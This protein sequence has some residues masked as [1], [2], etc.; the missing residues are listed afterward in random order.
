M[1]KCKKFATALSM[2]ALILP[3]GAGYAAAEE[4]PLDCTDGTM[5]PGLGIFNIQAGYSSSQPAPTG[6]VWGKVTAETVGENTKTVEA[7]T[8]ETEFTYR[9]R[10][11]AQKTAPTHFSISLTTTG[12][13]E[14]GYRIYLTDE[15]K[16]KIKD[17]DCTLNPK[18]IPAQG[19]ATATCPLLKNAKYFEIWHEDPGML[20]MMGR[21]VINTDNIPKAGAG[22]A[23]D[24]DLKIKYSGSSDAPAS[25]LLSATVNAGT[26][27]GTFTYKVKPGAAGKTVK[28]APKITVESTNSETAGE[29]TGVPEV[30]VTTKDAPAPEPGPAPAPEPAPIPA[31]AP[32]PAPTP[33]P[34]PGPAQSPESHSGPEK[35]IPDQA[36]ATQQISQKERLPRTGGAAAAVAA[37]AAMCIFAGARLKKRRN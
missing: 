36:A 22:A 23:A 10:A 35:I 8:Q 21:Y 30:T 17:S 28:S 19:K 5:C 37:A 13:F 6:K 7:G 3:F 20:D 33:K 31:P 34:E 2:G 26:W 12:L 14:R 29:V 9:V 27:E 16:T 32:A 24:R 25:S 4:K 11:T 1:G 18:K 15:H